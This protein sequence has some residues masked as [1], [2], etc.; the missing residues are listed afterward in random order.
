MKQSVQEFPHAIRICKFL[1]LNLFF[2]VFRAS[3]QENSW[4]SGFTKCSLMYEDKMYYL[5]PLGSALLENLG[6]FSTQTFSQG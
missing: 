5:D 6:H 3:G 4:P 1:M 2:P